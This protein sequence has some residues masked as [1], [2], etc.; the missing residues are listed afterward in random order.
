M[1]DKK[2]DERQQRERQRYLD[3]LTPAGR[4]RF[5]VIRSHQFANSIGGD[6]S[7]YRF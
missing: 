5:H 7:N 6:A 4:T 3:S 2:L 1:D